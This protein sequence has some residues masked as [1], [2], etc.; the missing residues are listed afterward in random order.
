MY[1]HLKGFTLSKVNENQIHIIA[2]MIQGFDWPP[3]ER[4]Y[5]CLKYVLFV[6]FANIG[7]GLTTLGEVFPTS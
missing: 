6:Y 3:E 1:I 5:K 2:Y 7:M 4:I